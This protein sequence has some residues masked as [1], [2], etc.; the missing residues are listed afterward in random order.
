MQFSAATAAPEKQKTDCAIV[1]VYQGK[2]LSRA[3]KQLDG[4]LQGQISRALKAGDISDSIGRTL[5]LQAPNKAKALRVMVVGCGK[6]STF[7]A[8]KNHRKAI[9]AALS[10]VTKTGATH[11]VSYLGEDLENAYEHGRAAVEIAN[12]LIYSAGHLKSKK[13][14]RPKLR[15]LEIHGESDHTS[16][17]ARGIKTGQAIA[18]GV[19][20][21]RELGDLPSNVCT[22]TYLAEQA[23]SLAERYKSLSCSIMGRATLE[24][25][26]FNCFLSV[27]AGSHEVPQF[28]TLKYQGGDKTDRP[29]AIIGKGITFD[30]GGISLKPGQGMDEM[31]YDMCGAAGVLGTMLALAKLRLNKN[32][33]AL[34]PACSNMPGGNATNPGDIIKT[35]SGKT[36]EIL[37]TDAEGRLIMCDA[38]T[39]AEE[40][41]PV[42]TLDVATLTGACVIALGHANTGLMSP[43]DDLVADLLRAGQDAADPAWRLPLSDEYGERLRSNFADMANVGGRPGGASAAAWF[44][45]QFTEKQNW[46]HLDVAGTAWRSGQRKGA[47]GRPV[48]MLTQYLMNLEA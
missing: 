4:A 1:G 44:L 27:S 32:V 43:H 19:A 24:K 8:Q 34:I 5:L 26:G 6:K 18:A 42:V 47:T 3:A 17:V 39:Y 40:F 22:P 31:K 33:V 38:L 2:K 20:L 23:K 25:K 28:I 41:D 30:T 10:A 29:V 9:R 35:L 11:A 7:S 36:V 15:K 12:E 48:P 13:A 46:A 37:N 45:S 21:A 16:D 14:P